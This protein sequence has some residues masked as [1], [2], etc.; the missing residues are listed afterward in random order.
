MANGERKN[1]GNG[2]NH[3]T[4]AATNGERRDPTRERVES[5]LETVR[6]R[7]SIVMSESFK[8]DVRDEYRKRG[9]GRPS[10]YDTNPEKIIE[11]G[12]KFAILGLP[13]SDM[14][15]WWGVCPDTVS[16]WKER[17]PEFSDVL[18]R[19]DVGRKISLLGAMH[20]NAIVAKIPSVQI[21]LAKN[22]LGYKD[23][24]EV[25]ANA[26]PMRITIVRAAKDEKH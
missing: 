2:G 24:I 8:G 10:I 20:H 26:D 11:E 3:R 5:V 21:F 19:G 13:Q 6:T 22:V 9:R 17:H 14:A 23:F 25:P 16:G 7:D 12:E 4:G 18:K 1:G 15:W